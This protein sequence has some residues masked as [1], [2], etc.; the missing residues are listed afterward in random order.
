VAALS[1]DSDFEPASIR[2]KGNPL[3]LS[4]TAFIPASPTRRRNHDAFPR[5][6]AVEGEKQY[7]QHAVVVTI[8]FYNVGGG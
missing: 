4:I 5:P 3:F 1:L 6:A 2:E 8:P 7:L